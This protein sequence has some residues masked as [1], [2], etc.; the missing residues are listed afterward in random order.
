MLARWLVSKGLTQDRPVG[1]YM[2]RSID[3][4]AGFIAALKANT[5]YVPLDISNPRHRLEMMIRDS[6]CGV[7]LTHRGLGHALPEGTDVMAVDE[8]M[9]GDCN[10]ICLPANRSSEELA[11]IIYTSGSTGVPKGVEGA[12]RASVNRFEWMWRAYPF[13]H[14]EMCCHKTALGFVDAVWEILGPL[15]GGTCSVI[16]ADRSLHDL[17]E[18]V[19]LLN[20]HRVTRIVLVPSLLNALLHAFPDLAASLPD[21]RLWTASGE[22]L[23]LDLARRFRAALPSARLLNIYGSSEGTADITCYEVADTEGLASI[24]IGR[25]ISN[26]QV[27]VLDERKNVV[28]PLVAGELHV[29]GACLARGY[30]RNKELTSQRFLPNPYSANFSPL[31]FATGDRGRLLSDGRIEYIG[32][33][34]AQIKL[35]GMRIELGEIESNLVAHPSVRSAAAGVYGDSPQTQRLVAH[36]EWAVAARVSSEGLRGFLRTR[37]PDYMI[38][39]EYIE[40]DRMP[41]L[42]SGKVDRGALPIPTARQRL[43]RTIVGGGTDIEKNLISIWM[44]VLALDE[45]GVNDD[46]F[47]LGGHSLSAMRV[48]SRMRRDFQV[49]V[50]MRV[51]FDRPTIAELALEIEQRKTEQGTLPTSAFSSGAPGSSHI[52]DILKAELR[53]LAPEQVDILLR[54]IGAERKTKPDDLN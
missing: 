32:R 18:F 20:R 11:Y 41:L 1:I 10:H 2:E 50:P 46:F 48:L 24:P 44:E 8:P 39:S 40:L 5:P 26:A 25:P 38:P 27:F 49:D 13:S 33:L 22:M 28:P 6:G 7:I 3:A 47:D 15:L 14:D 31:M 4:V 54:S 43:N 53:A 35:R 37:L 34:D 36:V 16:V 45:V 12:H 19:A 51:L 9:E 52:L 17:D 30:W 23:S 42:P 21:L 29:A